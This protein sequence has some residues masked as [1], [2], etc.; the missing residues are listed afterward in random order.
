MMSLKNEVGYPLM[1][2]PILAS[3]LCLKVYAS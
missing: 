2:R 1:P 3:W